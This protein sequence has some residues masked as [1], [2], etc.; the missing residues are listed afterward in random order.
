[1][2]LVVAVLTA[3]W[4]LDRATGLVAYPLL[5][6]AVVSGV[7]YSRKARSFGR[8]HRVARDWHVE[9]AVLATAVTLVH[10][11]LG[12]VDAAKYLS[13][14]VPDP[15]YPTPYFAAGVVV[16]TGSFLLVVVAA[17]GFLD[18]RRFAPPWDARAV[19]AFAYLGFGLGTVHAVA[20]GT[21]VGSL[22]RPAMLAAT[23]FVGYAVAIRTVERRGW[24]PRGSAGGNADAAD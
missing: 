20:I 4:V 8:L 17:L 15:A 16:G 22:L 10:G 13:G 5:W 12:L 18:A 19:H 2:G 9:V 6:L 11:L 21:D 23:L 3:V 7:F 1:M 24:W 14:V